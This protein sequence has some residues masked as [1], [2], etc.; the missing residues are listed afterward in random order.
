MALL[1]WKLFKEG[2]MANLTGL[3]SNL[4]ERNDMSGHKNK[5]IYCIL[6]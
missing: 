4:T 6:D 1:H 2:Q 5:D 3:D